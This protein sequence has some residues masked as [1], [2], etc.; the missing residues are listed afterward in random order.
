MSKEIVSFEPVFGCLIAALCAAIACFTLI[1]WTSSQ[2][3][4]AATGFLL[5]I[6]ARGIIWGLSQVFGY[7]KAKRENVE[8]QP[9]V[10]GAALG[11]VLFGL[12]LALVAVILREFAP[13][14]SKYSIISGAFAAFLLF[15]GAAVGIKQGVWR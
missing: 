12:M 11:C 3:S 8:M 14:Y 5:I 13:D 2:P 7:R 4:Y 10:L 1:S 9:P 6:G 15:V